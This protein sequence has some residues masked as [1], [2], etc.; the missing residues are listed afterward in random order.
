MPKPIKTGGNKKYLKKSTSNRKEDLQIKEH[1][2][3]YAKAIKILGG[4]RIE[5]AC[6]DG[7]VRLGHIRGSFK[8][9]KELAVGDILLAGLRDFQDSKCD[10]LVRYSPEDKRYLQS[11]NEIPTESELNNENS[12]E[13]EEGFTFEDI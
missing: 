13:A 8:N 12:N 3:V 11:I 2:Q 1:G 4:G 6:F 9:R 10:I 7:I 5:V